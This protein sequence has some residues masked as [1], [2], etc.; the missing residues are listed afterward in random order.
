MIT[1][2]FIYTEN[3]DV[4][5]ITI[6]H[7]TIIPQVG[8]YVAI[9]QDIKLKVISRTVCYDRLK[10]IWNILLEEQKEENNE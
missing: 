2:M 4:P 9:T 3:L 5:V 6:E 8:D 7:A 10:E 1:E